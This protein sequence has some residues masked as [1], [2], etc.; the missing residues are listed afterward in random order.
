MPCYKTQF[1]P[2]DKTFTRERAKWRFRRWRCH[3][4]VVGHHENIDLIAAEVAEWLPCL[5]NLTANAKRKRMIHQKLPVKFN[6]LGYWGNLRDQL[7]VL[8]AQIGGLFDHQSALIRQ[9]KFQAPPKVRGLG[10]HAVTLP[11]GLRRIQENLQQSSHV[12]HSWSPII[13]RVHRNYGCSPPHR[14][15]NLAKT[16][17]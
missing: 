15:T 2:F 6:M 17:L 14:V 13:F 10:G 7:A 16:Q 9:H 4:Q 5:C 12:I 1:D 11:T 8:V 3:N